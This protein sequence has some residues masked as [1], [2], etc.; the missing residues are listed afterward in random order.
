[1]LVRVEIVRVV[2]AILCIA[3]ELAVDASACE[4]HAH[5]GAQAR[6]PGQ[7]QI[8]WHVVRTGA[9]TMS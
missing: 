6:N 3:G 9:H 2:C 5:V 1:M 4:M 7:M 8:R